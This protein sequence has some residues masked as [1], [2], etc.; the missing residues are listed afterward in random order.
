M[1]RPNL[2]HW[3]KR[4]WALA[5][6]AL[7]AFAAA[8]FAYYRQNRRAPTV[9]LVMSAGDSI[10]LRHHMAHVM[11]RD[12]SHRG[13]IMNI[14]P[15]TGSEECLDRIENGSIQVAL[16]NG[17]LSTGSRHHIRQVA[18]LHVEPMH[19]LVRGSLYEAVTAKLDAL[20][21][22]RVHIGPPG[23]GS[24]WMALE[25]L[26]FGGLKV[27]DESGRP[28][29]FTVTTET[30]SQL[31]T[32]PFR[33]EELPDAV[34]TISS[35]PSPVARRLV[36]EFGYR[37][38]PLPFGEAFALGALE[39][40]AKLADEAEPNPQHGV[41]KE[42]VYD[43]IIPAYTY[44]IDP[45]VP[46]EPIHSLG[47]RLILVARDTVP[48]DVV[49]RLIDAVY[50]TRIAKMAHPALE[51]K[52]LQIPP[53]YTPHP[54]L[55]AY[56]QRN[57][58]LITGEVFD[59][60][61]KLVTIGG[62]AVGGLLFCLQWF[63]Q[64]IRWHRDLRFE[65]YIQKVTQIEREAMDHELSATLQLRPLLDLQFALGRLKAEALDK[66]A[67]GELQGAEYL[68]GFLNHVND[69]RAYLARLILHQREVIEDRA[70]QEGRSA[71]ALWLEAA[72]AQ[73]PP[74]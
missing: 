12:L 71:R 40:N 27:P 65:N 51:P 53:E 23:S 10:G 15:T 57:K 37:L 70:L 42:H 2:H 56:M 45:D 36:S 41:R 20:R 28:G 25:V 54:G 39:Q 34:F 33:P 21:G 29:E 6:L 73:A 3:R 47:S 26:R 4:D 35:L 8:G 5:L 38:V 61:E 59:G 72:S 31:A 48:D 64:R 44:G 9:T 69:T 43:T 11:A 30:L 19:L 16:I 50:S 46:A 60:M 32:K 18:T 24:H 58:P 17:A 7:T 67:T 74:S 68:T 66:F 55:V 49:G 52:L 14:Q 13:I 22:K 63:R 62:G 1:A